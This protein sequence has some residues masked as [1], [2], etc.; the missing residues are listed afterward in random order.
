MVKYSTSRLD[1]VF[2]ALADPTRREILRSVARRECSVTELAAP[3]EMSLAAVSKHLKVLEKANLIH[4]IK[5]GRTSYCRLNAEALK[6]AEQW[7]ASYARFW[8]TR[9][10]ALE[11]LVHAPVKRKKEKP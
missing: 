9:L 2:R 7:I 3:F 8:E 5:S 6:T 1:G 4:R 11:T 10:D